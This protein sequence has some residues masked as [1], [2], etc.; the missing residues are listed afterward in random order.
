[1]RDF[2]HDESWSHLSVAMLAGHTYF[3]VY[4][5]IRGGWT[6]FLLRQRAVTRIE[7]LEDV[8]EAQVKGFLTVSLMHVHERRPRLSLCYEYMLSPLFFGGGG[9]KLFRFLPL[10]LCMFLRPSNISHVQSSFRFRSW[11]SAG[12]ARCAPSATPSSA[13]TL[14]PRLVG[15]ST[16][17]QKSKGGDRYVCK[18]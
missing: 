13:P 8:D 11:P 14:P 1:M 17:R 18:W 16:Q 10:P 5:R 6:K 12:L 4:L 7:G 2:W 3:N 15:H 9:V